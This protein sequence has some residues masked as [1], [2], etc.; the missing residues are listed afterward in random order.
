MD[1]RA[2]GSARSRFIAPKP[3]SLRCRASGVL[4]APKALRANCDFPPWTSSGRVLAV[5]KVAGKEHRPQR[6]AR[7]EPGGVGV[8]RAIP[9]GPGWMLPQTPIVLLG[10]L[11]DYERRCNPDHRD[12]EGG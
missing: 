7:D 1:R 5:P 8:R 4:R 2:D 6:Q 12:H 9:P 3:G 10:I 11:R